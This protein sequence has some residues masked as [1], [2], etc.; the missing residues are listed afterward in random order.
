MKSFSLP[1]KLVILFLAV[2]LA[3]CDKFSK[4]T[5]VGDNKTAVGQSKPKAPQLPPG[6]VSIPLD[7]PKN[8]YIKKQEINLVRRP[9]MEPVAGKVSYDESRTAR[10]ASPIA[11]R[12]ISVPQALGTMVKKGQVLLTIDSPDL[13]S[14]QSDF[15]KAKADLELSEKSYKRQKFLYEHGAVARKE[16]ESAQDEWERNQ[17][18]LQRAEKRLV[19]L[20]ATPGRLDNRFAL[21]S[22]INGAITER[23]ITPGM[24]VR[25]DLDDPLYVISDLSHLWVLMDVFERNLGLI[26]VGQHVKVSVPAYP[27]KVFPA[28][29]EYISKMVDETTRTIKIRCA[30]DNPGGKLLPAMYATVEVESAPSDLAIVIPLTAIFTEEESDWVFVKIGEGLYKKRPVKIGLRLKDR[31]V[32]ESGLADGDKIVVD[33]ALLLRSEEYFEES[34]DSSSETAE[35]EK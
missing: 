29:I 32:I 4:S 35:N 3:G 9:L 2:G 11:G 34:G 28:K 21:L 19:N 18:E 30:L 7:S 8:A 25:P 26:Y 16:F 10:I 33:G 5:Q 24:E 13:G 14:A 27:G 31:A 12:V 6:E 22:P 1:I 17:S 20:N 15:A 23:H